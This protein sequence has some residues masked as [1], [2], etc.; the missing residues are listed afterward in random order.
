MAR[1]E[2][3]ISA[4]GGND[5]NLGDYDRRTPLHLAAAEGFLGVTTFLI[6]RAGAQHSPL[7]RW[8]GSPLQ[9]A[10]RS[11]HVAVA[12]YLAAQG[13]VS[14][15]PGGGAPGGGGAASGRSETPEDLRRDNAI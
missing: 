13:A 7:D 11:G 12:T 10:E 14:G 8:H 1:L 3:L 6:E 4:D 15:A 5:V 9:D 2:R